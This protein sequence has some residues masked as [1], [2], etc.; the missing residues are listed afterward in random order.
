MQ[1]SPTEAVTDCE[2]A[3]GPSIQVPAEAT[4]AALVS[5][6][7]AP[8][9]PP[10]EAANDTDTPCMGLPPRSETR[11]AGASGTDVPATTVC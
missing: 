10:A 3:A 11:T 4:P 6:D 8:T 1:P 7:A 5:A 2:P 9:L